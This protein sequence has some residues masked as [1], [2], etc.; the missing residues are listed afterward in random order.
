[1]NQHVAMDEHIDPETGEITEVSPTTVPTAA[2]VDAPAAETATVEAVAVPDTEK[3]KMPLQPILEEKVPAL[4]TPA[5]DRID[6]NWDI[7]QV[8]TRGHVHLERFFVLSEKVFWPSIII[9]LVSFV[10]IVSPMMGGMRLSSGS[11]AGAGGVKLFVLFMPFWLVGAVATFALLR[12]GGQ[13]MDGTT[14]LVGGLV[15]GGFL[16]YL[17][18]G[19]SANPHGT[20]AWIITGAKVLFAVGSIIWIAHHIRNSIRGGESRPILW[21]AGGYVALVVVGAVILGSISTALSGFGSGGMRD[22]AAMLTY[23]R[24]TYFDLGGGLRSGPE[25]R[26][27]GDH[28]PKGGLTVSKLNSLIGSVQLDLAKHSNDAGS[29]EEV[30]K[31]DTQPMI[32]RP[33]K[34]IR[35]NAKELPNGIVV[36]PEG[37]DPVTIVAHVEGQWSITLVAPR[38]CAVVLG[39]FDPAAGCQ[40]LTTP[41]QPMNGNARRVLDS[42]M[43]ILAAETK[44]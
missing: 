17:W 6:P 31:L 1:M 16:L 35:D 24:D 29:W 37:D 25:Y 9:A 3:R 27:L 10:L 18:M 28:A 32:T 7:A 21:L 20:A 26:W 33:E 2:Q 42:I 19:S 23:D 36:I 4:P 12:A 8:A 30:P 38:N 39:P 22:I 11:G 5:A 13:Q 43:P 44:E 14:V 34:A 15:V 40:N 41:N